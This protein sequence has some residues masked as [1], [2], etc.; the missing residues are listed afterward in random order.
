MKYRCVAEHRRE[1]PVTVMCRL[2]QIKPSGFCAWHRRPESPRR[3]EDDRQ[4]TAITDIHTESD[5]V[6]RSPK[7]RDRLRDL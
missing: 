1:Y 5:G 2:L 6:Y 3:V 7:V 4:K